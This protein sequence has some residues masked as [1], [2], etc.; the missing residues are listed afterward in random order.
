[1]KTLKITIIAENAAKYRDR[2]LNL[3]PGAEILAFEDEDAALNRGLD[4]EVIAVW[5]SSFP[6]QFFARAENLKWVHSLSAGVEG[7]VHPAWI[8]SPVVMT[9]SR[10]V[11]TKPMAEYVI[12]MILAFSRRLNDY[13][14]Q[15]QERKW[16]RLHCFEVDGLTLGIVGLGGIGREIAPR[17]K[18]LGMRVIGTRNRPAPEPF[19]DEVLPANR[20]DEL[21]RVSDFVVVAAPLVP[22]TRGLLS[23]ARLRLMKPTA[24]LIN[25][26]RGPLVDEEALIRILQGGAIAGAA[27]DVFSQEPLPVESPLWGLPNVI[28]TPHWSASSPHNVTRALDVFAENIRRY[29]A[30]EPLLNVVDK[31]LGY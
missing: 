6:E 22:E 30:G 14:R 26:A 5:G 25:V 16:E 27:L 28:V 24:Y 1:V 9:N 12:A 7:L 10:G 31:S 11:Y 18:G 13:F 19:V 20:L 2:L 21:L 4:S 15:Q 8:A 3:V 29:Q 23:E 17:A